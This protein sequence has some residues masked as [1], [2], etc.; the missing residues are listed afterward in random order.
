MAFV[1][2]DK[3]KRYAET[4]LYSAIRTGK[5]KI[6]Q[7]HNNSIALTVKHVNGSEQDTNWSLNISHLEF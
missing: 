4:S 5:W 3:D 1:S 7:H 6:E 2:S